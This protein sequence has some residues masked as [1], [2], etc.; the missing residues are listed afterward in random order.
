MDHSTAILEDANQAVQAAEAAQNT[1]A[2]TNV[3]SEPMEPSEA[4]PPTDNAYDEERKSNDRKR[5][6]DFPSDRQAFGSRGKDGGGGRGGRNDG[7]RHKKGDMGRGEY[8]RNDPDKRARTEASRQ[9]RD[10]EGG[11]GNGNAT[12]YGTTFSQEEIDAEGRK[13]K[14]KVAV[15]IG[16]SGTGYKGMQI[17]PHEE[18]IEG[19]LFKAFVKAG[20]I[21]KANADDPKKASLV[22]CA[23]TD[24]GVHAAGNMISLKLIVEEDDIVEKINAALSPQIRVWGIERTIGS[25][26]CYQACDSRWYEYLIPSHAF[27]PPHPSSWLAKKLE[28]IADQTG[29]H[30]A[31]ESR[32]AEVRGYWE[33]VD[34]E[35]I[36][37]VLESID[38]DIRFDVVKA[39][40]GEEEAS[41]KAARA[42]ADVDQNV[43][44][45]KGVGGGKRE[46]K[47]ENEDTKDE[48]TEEAAIIVNEPAVARPAPVDDTPAATAPKEE[49]EAVV[50]GMVDSSAS[51]PI[52]QEPEASTANK[53]TTP[54]GK[55]LLSPEEF[56]RQ[57]RLR[58]ATKKLR[59]AY[60]SAKRAYRIPEQ[61]VKR[62]QDALSK[63]KGTKN[64][65]NFT[66]QKTF[67]DPSAKRF[68]KSFIV[69]PKPILIKG[70][71][72]EGNDGDVV[73]TEWLS[74]KVH[75]QSFMMHQIRKMI[76]MV[77]LLVRCG[78]DLSTLDAS[79]QEE[80]FSI[81]K[82]PGLGLLL[83]RPVF[84]SYNDIQAPKHGRGQLRFDKY[85]EAME[86]FKQR[87]I[88]QRIFREEE[89]RNEFGRFFNHVDNFKEPYFLYVTSKGLEA[90][91]RQ[92]NGEDAV[93]GAV[94]EE[95]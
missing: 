14:R 73:E 79:M 23:R 39:L 21:S 37:P 16:Y 26:S 74:M 51:L 6:A 86:E 87:E 68:I 91:K 35:Y 88:Y 90:T 84:D 9:K 41:A 55:P 61:R 59:N 47:A 76:G 5:K 80:K 24:K 11:S 70:K 56:D 44:G 64:Y 17:T 34:E 89:E 53:G 20:A 82:V 48:K 40:Q 57:Q 7:K 50:E 18:T 63:Y 49:P 92:K 66:I 30:E 83:E 19:D 33:K 32:Q 67:R 78:S 77:A 62:I 65:H 81:P 29:D 13:P 52:K 36:K 8:F 22:R 85:E 4:A 46:P 15:L 42:E 69:N 1:P 71:G 45:G 10:Q 60:V 31:Y 3:T 72:G 12:T 25:F 38:E 93:A 75:G 2:T 95:S 27:L 58:A 43:K 54:S 28:E 94:K